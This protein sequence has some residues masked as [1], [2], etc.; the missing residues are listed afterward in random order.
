MKEKREVQVQVKIMTEK[1]AMKKIKMIDELRE[2]RKQYHVDKDM[3][4][5]SVSQFK[6]G[7]MS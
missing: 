5:E 4:N 6:A 7:N 1:L 3:A 2:L